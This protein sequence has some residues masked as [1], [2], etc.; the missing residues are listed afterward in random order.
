MLDLLR[1]IT[2]VTP[3]PLVS[4]RPD[5]P[6]WLGELIDRCIAKDPAARPTA[7]DVAGLC[8]ARRAPLSTP[9]KPLPA[10]KPTPRRI[11]KQRR[12]ATARHPARV[13]VAVG[14]VAILTCVIAC[15]IAFGTWSRAQPPVPPSPGPVATVPPPAPVRSA[16]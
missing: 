4:V 11:T 13:P 3:P 1:E 8:A 5:V 10:E 15:V 16:W 2:R 6:P 9:G 14:A 12:H 7:E